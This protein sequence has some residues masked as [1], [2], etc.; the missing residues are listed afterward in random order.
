[1]KRTLITCAVAAR[2][3]VWKLLLLL[4]VM[5]AAEIGLL[6][7]FVWEKDFGDWLYVAHI[8]Q[9]FG[10]GFLALTAVL[11][12][13]GC[14]F[15]GGKLGYTLRRLPQGERTVSLLWA[16]VHFAAYVILWAA[17]VGLV[18]LFWQIYARNPLTDGS[19]LE[20]LVACYR[21]NFLHRLLPMASVGSWI[22]NGLW[23]L[24]LSVQTVAVGWY[25]RRGRLGLWPLLGLCAWPFLWPGIQ[26]LTTD[27][28][29][30]LLFGA[31]L[32]GGLYLLLRREP[33]EA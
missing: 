24:S 12:L 17:Q 31:Y 21:D 14:D 33:D 20:L 10:L 5:A 11:S 22:V 30:S 7:A 26:S 16:M 13:Q 27:T 28:I 18:L 3:I 9:A 6:R 4:T 8:K 25:Q 15:G 32:V 29:W 23:L 2:A 1:M 19:R